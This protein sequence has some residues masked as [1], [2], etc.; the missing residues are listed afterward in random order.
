MVAF[1]RV[2]CCFLLA[3][4][5]GLR[6]GSKILEGTNPYTQNAMHFLFTTQVIVSAKHFIL[7][8]IVTE[9]LQYA[10]PGKTGAQV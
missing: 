8:L 10:E 4:N 7:V 1:G 9:G 3:E 2:L 6:Q 5:A